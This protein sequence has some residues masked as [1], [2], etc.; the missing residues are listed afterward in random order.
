M[1]TNGD[2]YHHPDEEAL[3]CIVPSAPDGPT[4]WFNHR[5]QSTRP[6]G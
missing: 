4:L 3:A 2:T 1:S 5:S 6:V